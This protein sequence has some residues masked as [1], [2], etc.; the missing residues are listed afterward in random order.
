[1]TKTYPLI[2]LNGFIYMVDKKALNDKCPYIDSGNELHKEGSDFHGMCD[3][4]AVISS[5]DPSLGLPLLPDIE[6][7]INQLG[8]NFIN[9]EKQKDILKWNSAQ[10]IDYDIKHICKKIPNEEWLKKK[11]Y[12]KIAI[13]K[14]AGWIEGYIAA[15]AKGYTEE[16]MK[17]IV[18]CA[19]DKQCVDEA[20]SFENWFKRYLQSLNPLP[21]AVEVEM[22]IDNPCPKC[23]KDNTHGN[24]DYSKPN[25]PLIDTLCNE[26]GTVFLP[27]P[28]VDENNIIQIVKWIYGNN[29]STR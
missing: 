26:C 15:K 3:C 25:T 9:S 8:L 2:H 27:I 29:I 6:E 13:E 21:I 10:F 7:N 5:N 12:L 28:K 4:S 23:G 19:P 1:M 22:D 16:D 11:L 24:Y 17:D 20:G 18:L 14:K